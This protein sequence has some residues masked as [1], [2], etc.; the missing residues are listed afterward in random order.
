M[1]YDPDRRKV[2][3]FGGR[4]C[5]PGQVLGDVWEYDGAT[6]QQRTL[7]NG[8]SPRVRG[9]VAYDST[10]QKLV[11]FGGWSSSAATG[12]ALADTWELDATGWRDVTADAG[13]A[14]SAR[15]THLAFDSVRGVTVLFSGSAN[16]NGTNL[17]P[18]TWEYNGT[19]TRRQGTNNPQ[20]RVAAAMA[21]DPVAQRVWLAGGFNGGA[22][23]AVALYD[24]SRWNNSNDGDGLT[25]RYDA[26]GV[27]DPFS[28]RFV[29]LG[30]RNGANAFADVVT[31]T[32]TAI[33]SL[34]P[35]PAPR[36]SHGAA[37]DTFRNVLVVFGGDAAGCNND[38]LEF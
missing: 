21:Y 18:D 27:F 25:A 3:I 32:T 10:R 13:V 6:W 37:F 7:A 33:G 14:P 30:G 15:G 5:N 1:V 2:V 16:Y 35:L 9:A 20:N 19:W 36:H 17:Q 4:S 26:P 24:G 34:P 23:S 38:T 8:P 12:G 22:L 11:L 31:F 28:N 29:I